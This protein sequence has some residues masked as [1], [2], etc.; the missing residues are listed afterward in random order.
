MVTR[1]ARGVMPGSRKW[2]VHGPATRL[3]ASCN[4]A[5]SQWSLHFAITS[6]VS[7]F[8]NVVSYCK[9]DMTSFYAS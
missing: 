9:R 6:A 7:C 1:A 4:S 3:A 5:L 8:N 2:A